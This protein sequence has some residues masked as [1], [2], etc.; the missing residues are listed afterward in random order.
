MLLLFNNTIILDVKWNIRKEVDNA[1][2]VLLH[3]NGESKKDFMNNIFKRL[4]KYEDECH[5]WKNRHICQQN[6]IY[7]YKDS[8][9]VS[10]EH[11]AIDTYINCTRSLREL[12]CLNK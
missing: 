10:W 1:E 4:C 9:V 3:Y 6:V 12:F 7:P 11:M 5:D 8:R 2:Q